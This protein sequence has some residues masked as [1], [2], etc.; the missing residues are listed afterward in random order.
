M[1]ES[2]HTFTTSQLTFYVLADCLAA[3]LSEGLR[4]DPQII[5]AVGNVWEFYVNQAGI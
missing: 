2:G 3:I 1:Q 4:K 5:G